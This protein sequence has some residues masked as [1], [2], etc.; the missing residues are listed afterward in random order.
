[1]SSKINGIDSRPAAIGAGQAVQRPKDAMTGGP[2]GSVAGTADVH[3]T[4]TAARLAALEQAL[5]DLPA[6]DEARVAE[7]RFAIEEGRY[8]VNP[9]RIADQLL[10]LEQALRGLQINRD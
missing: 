5:L 6:I 1:M 9:D 8:T 7:I 10:Q 3:I 4:G 2:S